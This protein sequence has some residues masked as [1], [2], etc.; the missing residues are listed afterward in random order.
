[1]LEFI[2]QNKEWLFSGVGIAVIGAIFAWF[3]QIKTDKD[4][5]P[6]VVI[7]ILNNPEVTQ[8]NDETDVTSASIERISPVTFEMM[9]DAI[10]NAP[11]LQ[12]DDVKRNYVG[13]K[14]EWDAFLKAAN[15]DDEGFVRLRLTTDKEHSLNTIYC[16]VLL[17]E[18]R[19][20][21]VLPEGAKIRIHGEIEE[22]DTWDIRLKDVKLFIY[23]E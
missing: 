21:G 2:Q 9:K 5:K 8:D 20:L 1:M 18:Y 3:R 14:I 13:I 12:R 7:H 15:K 19:E 22:A 17:D 6:Q 16:K 4:E 10:E 11:P 23:G